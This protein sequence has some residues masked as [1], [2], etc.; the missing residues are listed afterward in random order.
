MIRRLAEDERIIL[1]VTHDMEFLNC[2]CGRTV[3]L[4]CNGNGKEAETY[5]ERHDIIR[6][7]NIFA[8]VEDE[9]RAVFQ[10]NDR[11]GEGVMVCYTVFPGAYLFYN[12]F[13]SKAANAS[14]NLT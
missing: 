7:K 1:I 10:M 13:H 2:V 12:D 5:A 8:V 9:E 14:F 11:T 4:A 6:R 3:T